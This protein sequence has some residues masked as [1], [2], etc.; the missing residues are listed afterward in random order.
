VLVKFFLLNISRLLFALA[1]LAFVSCG[2]LQNES[3]GVNLSSALSTICNGPVANTQVYLTQISTTTYQITVIPSLVSGTS[4]SVNFFL[5]SNNQGI[6][7]LTQGVALTQSA[8]ISAGTASVADIQGYNIF[9]I[10][11]ADSNLTGVAAAS[12]SQSA[13]CYL[14]QI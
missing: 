2:R 3:T 5:Y 6:K 12:S 14:P 1:V 13:V 4:S 11:P 8:Q 10:A 9:V 7:S